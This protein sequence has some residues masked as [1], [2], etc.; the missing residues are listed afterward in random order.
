LEE[1]SFL[2]FSYILVESVNCI[3]I[4]KEGK[5]SEKSNSTGP[6][7]SEDVLE[8]LIVNA[9]SA[10]QFMLRFGNCLALPLA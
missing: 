2:C 5:V 9:L 10:L 7:A 1:R 4:F 8:K 3:R 6:G